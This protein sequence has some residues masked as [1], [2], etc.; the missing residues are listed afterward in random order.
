MLDPRSGCGSAGGASD[1]AETSKRG[2]GGSLP[3]TRGRSR[4]RGVER[5][6][7]RPQSDGKGKSKAGEADQ[8]SELDVVDESGNSKGA[9]IVTCPRR[10][11]AR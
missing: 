4:T 8:D 2:T 5:G 10:V 11:V 9:L 1:L 3:M 6:A 7:P